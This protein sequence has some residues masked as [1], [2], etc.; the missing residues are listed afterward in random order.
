MQKILPHRFTPAVLLIAGVLASLCSTVSA[1]PYAYVPNEKDGTV[2]VID[3]ST[4]E[5]ISTLP[6]KAGSAKK[7]RLP[8]YILLTNIYM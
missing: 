4:D 3:T 5:V 6:K 1:Q 2:S 8:P 7:C